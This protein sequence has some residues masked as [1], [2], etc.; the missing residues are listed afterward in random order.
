[1]TI[2][3]LC[4]RYAFGIYFE[5]V[6]LFKLPIIIYYCFVKISRDKTKLGVNDSKATLLELNRAHAF[7]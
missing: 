6:F 4:S 1:M 7:C 5:S 3:S 2:P